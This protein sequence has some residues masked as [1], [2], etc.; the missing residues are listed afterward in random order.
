MEETIG[1]DDLETKMVTK[2][3]SDRLPP[4]RYEAEDLEDEGELFIALFC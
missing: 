1:T 2:N 3:P 4:V